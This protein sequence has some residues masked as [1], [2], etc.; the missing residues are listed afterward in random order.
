M[1][2]PCLNSY[3]RTYAVQQGELGAVAGVLA[4]R[5]VDVVTNQA[6]NLGF[7]LVHSLFKG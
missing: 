3:L 4:I 7:D 5:S 2:C 1:F 6:Q